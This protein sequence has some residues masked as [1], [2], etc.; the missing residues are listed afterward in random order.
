MEQSAGTE[1]FSAIVTDFA[2]T[3]GDR[4]Q[5]EL[6]SSPL[7]AALRAAGTSHIY[8][9]T[10]DY[11]DLENLL[12]VADGKLIAEVDGNTANQPL[13]RKVIGDYLDEANL[14][15]WAEALRRRREEITQ[16]ELSVTIYAIVCGRVGNDFIVEFA[17]G[18]PWEISLQLHM[19]LCGDADSARQVGRH[20]R[21][22]V[23]S[24]FV[25]VPFTPHYPHCF[26]VARDLEKEGIPVNF[27]STFSARQAVAAAL[28]RNVTRTNIFMGRINQG[29]KS[30]LLGEHVD[31]EAQRT[32]TRLRREE[33]I[34]TQLIVASMH[35]WQTLITT[36]GCDAY[37]AP[38][39]VIRDF[40]DQTEVSPDE[41]TS[42]LFT[43]YEGRFSV[44]GDVISRLG[45]ERTAKLYQ[46]EP[47]FIEFLNEYRH[48]VEYRNLADGDRLFRRFDNAGFGDLF[49]APKDAEW[50]EIRRDKI[51]QLDAPLTHRLSL[52]TLYTLLADADFEKYQDEMD[53]E[54]KK[55]LEGLIGL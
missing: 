6:I 1:F 41:I 36:A 13:V 25:K 9:D 38:V 40:L 35:E 47:E 49:Y 5:S 31:L 33:G 12:S 28:L 10:A 8:A 14:N 20:I 17:S 42:K 30:E 52:D 2:R 24:A 37:T 23:P 15:G 32:L 50:N 48:T 18:R 16:P 44:A 39:S 4:V 7:L 43:S 21:S 29:L 53:R 51:P 19:G 11:R 45:K 26:L 34:K 54:I 3:G 27:T 55:R 22:M 46:V